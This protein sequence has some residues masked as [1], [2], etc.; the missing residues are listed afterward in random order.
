VLRKDDLKGFVLVP[1]RWVSERTFS[2]LGQS[3]RLNKDYQ[4][5]TCSSETM[6]YLAMIYLTMIYLM[7]RRLLSK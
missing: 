4:R 1:K 6:I 7:V 3:R 5:L 2:W